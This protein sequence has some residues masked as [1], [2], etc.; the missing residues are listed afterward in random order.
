MF[1]GYVIFFMIYL[2]IELKCYNDLDYLSCFFGV[3][4]Y[5]VNEICDG[6]N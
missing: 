4:C 2:G 6:L 3:F 1:D 5:Y